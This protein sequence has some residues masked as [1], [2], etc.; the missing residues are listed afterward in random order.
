MHIWDCKTIDSL[1]LF[2]IIFV[3]IHCL[4]FKFFFFLFD[5]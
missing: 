5:V 1:L 3:S 2:I 4:F